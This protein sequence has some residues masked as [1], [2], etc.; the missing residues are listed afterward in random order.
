MVYRFI[1]LSE[2]EESFQATIEIDANS[3]FLDLRNY[4]LSILSYPKDLFSTF[5]V[6]DEHWERNIEIPQEEMETSSDEDSYEMASA[7]IESFVDEDTKE[8]EFVF[9]MFQERSLFIRLLGSTSRSVETPKLIDL[10]GRVP[11]SPS[12]DSQIDL[13]PM[14]EAG[15]S[16]IDIDDDFFGENIDDLDELMSQGLTDDIEY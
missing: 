16:S 4:L 14:G 11:K 15:P 3:T 10:Q 13:S 2:E 9:D 12:I 1:L 7:I 6:C 8:V 5:F